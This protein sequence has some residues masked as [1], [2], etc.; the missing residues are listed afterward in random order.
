MVATNSVRKR[1]GN[2]SAGTSTFAM[3]VLEKELSRAHAAID[4]V[5][6]LMGRW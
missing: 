1:T 4:L 3:I 5:T 6:T 2:I